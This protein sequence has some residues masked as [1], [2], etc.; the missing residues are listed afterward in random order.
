ARMELQL[1]VFAVLNLVGDAHAH[2]LAASAA[3]GE[4]RALGDDHVAAVS[5]A[6]LEIAARGGAVPHRR[7]HLEEAVADG[8]ERVLEAVL[9]HARVAIADL[10]AERLAEVLHDGREL[11]SHQADLPHAKVHGRGHWM[12]PSP[13]R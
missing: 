9:A 1:V 5:A 11:A 2:R 10:E 13:V 6:P 3:R 4:I 7:H 12:P 8:E